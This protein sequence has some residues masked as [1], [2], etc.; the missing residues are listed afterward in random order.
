MRWL[1]AMM[2][3]MALIGADTP[4]TPM[5]TVDL[6]KAAA[7][8]QKPRADKFTPAPSMERFIGRRFR[9]TSFFPELINAG[10]PRRVGRIGGW[11]YDPDRQLLRL[12]PWVGVNS[13]YE[14]KSDPTLKDIE[15]RFYGFC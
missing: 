8:F 1:L 14:L 7:D 15:K 2:A 11:T 6:V 12:V 4:D 5:T 9:A 3:F 10:G 13:G